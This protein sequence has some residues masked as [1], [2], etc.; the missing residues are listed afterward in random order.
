MT[1]IIKILIF[2]LLISIGSSIAINIFDIS[3]GTINYWQNHGFFLLIFLALF[4]RLT[5]LFSSIASG[6][7]FWWLGWIFVPRVLVAILATI[8]YWQTN[9]ILVIFSWL[10][11]VS[12]ESSEKTFIR[13]RTKSYY[14]GQTLDV[15]YTVKK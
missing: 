5:L 6:G 12:G 2:F 13:S 3:Y 8:S 15:S 7:I 10:F 1:G 9:K 4:P 14:D 11:A